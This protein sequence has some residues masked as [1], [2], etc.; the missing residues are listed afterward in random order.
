MNLMLVYP[1]GFPDVA[2]GGHINIIRGAHLY[3]D[4]TAESDSA[5]MDSVAQDENMANGW[6]KGKKHPVTGEPLRCERLNLPPGS[7]ICCNTR[8]VL[9]RSRLSFV[10][11][12]NR[13]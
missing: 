9:S 3:C 7:L 5:A 12:M 10:H 4:T 13:W 8:A 6:M 1:A 2:D 11:Q